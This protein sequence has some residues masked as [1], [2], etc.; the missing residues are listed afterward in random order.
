MIW[1]ESGG[2]GDLLVASECVCVDVCVDQG[3][4][5]PSLCGARAR[6]C[7]G[8]G[9]VVSAV[10]SDKFTHLSNN[11]IQ[12]H[13]ADFDNTDIDGNMWLCG[14]FEEWIKQQTVG[15]TG[16]ATSP[17][18]P[19]LPFVSMDAGVWV[20]SPAPLVVVVVVALWQGEDLWHSKVQPKMKEIVVLALQSAQDMVCFLRVALCGRLCPFYLGVCELGDVDLLRTAP[21]PPCV[22]QLMSLMRITA[23]VVDAYHSSCRCVIGCRLRTARTP[24][25]STGTTS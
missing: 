19:F 5:C 18:P 20:S 3:L 16:L 23:H 12:K 22:S 6:L 15:C 2:G 17:V 1:Y 10:Q 11:S 7:V 25:R 24:S 9:P 4:C 14:Q 8:C 21:P 13:C